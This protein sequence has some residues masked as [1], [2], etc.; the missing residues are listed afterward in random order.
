MTT[1]NLSKNDLEDISYIF[2]KN[3]YYKKSILELYKKDINEY[4]EKNKIKIYDIEIKNNI[5]NNLSEKYDEF[6]IRKLNPQL[7]FIYFFDYKLELV[8]NINNI[9]QLK[10][11]YEFMI[12][13]N[14]EEYNEKLRFMNP[15][16]YLYLNKNN[17]DIKSIIDKKYINL[18]HLNKDI[19]FIS[20]INQSV[21]I[22]TQGNNINLSLPTIGVIYRDHD[23]KFKNNTIVDFINKIVTIKDD[24]TNDFKYC[25]S[26]ISLKDLKLGNIFV[27]IL[28][29]SNNIDN[30]TINTFK[31]MIDNININLSDILT[32]KNKNRLSKNIKSVRSEFIIPYKNI[33]KKNKDDV[34]LLEKND[35]EKYKKP[36][37]LIE[38]NR[39][40]LKYVLDKIKNNSDNKLDTKN[41]KNVLA[42]YLFYIINLTSEIYNA[43]IDKIDVFFKTL[44]QS[45][46]NLFSDLDIINAF[47]YTSL[48]KKSIYKFKLILLNNFHN[49]FLPTQILEGSYGMKLNEYG[50]YLPE[51]ILLGD[52]NVIKEK[53]PFYS[54]DNDIGSDPNKLQKYILNI[55]YTNDIYD[56]KNILE[57]GGNIY[58]FE[59]MKRTILVLL[60]Y[61]NN[62]EIKNNFNLFIINLLY[63]NWKNKNIIP[64]EIIN[65]IISLD[66]Y[67]KLFFENNILLK[68][69][70]SIQKCVFYISNVINIRN[71]RSN[72]DNQKLN[73]LEDINLLSYVFYNMRCLSIISYVKNSFININLKNKILE[74]LLNKKSKYEK[75]LLNK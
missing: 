42:C 36:K 12:K 68:Y 47:N 56:K 60:N 65:D 1:K 57:I 33:E 67:N 66:K 2:N 15:L 72:L 4:I 75:L 25:C 27:N 11:I 64:I 24:Q 55:S 13:K 28:F 23:D 52:N 20:K 74:E 53:Y 46:H 73:R 34:V 16:N 50:S 8:N 54:K 45:K 39:N 7:Y 58:D 22:L 21:K 59:L 10:E 70:D 31:N 63:D 37:D 9:N 40:I 6:I 44:I 49:F 38:K 29:K 17:I 61:Y 62:M 3:I 69:E 14:V 35:Y 32:I 43:Y 41:Y 19:D 26:N 30:P 5:L 48:L 51:S 18:Y 71:K